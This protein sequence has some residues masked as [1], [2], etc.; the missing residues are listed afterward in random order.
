MKLQIKEA[1]L[2]DKVFTNKESSFIIGLSINNSYFK[3][4]NIKKLLVWSS[5]HAK[6]TYVMIPD[7]PMV[8]TFIALGY[9]KNKAEKIARLKANALENK[10]LRLVQ[11]LDLVYVT[12]IRWGSIVNNEHYIN[13][14][15]Q[16]KE[17]YKLDNNFN[18]AIR[19]ATVEVVKNNSILEITEEKINIGVEFFL[20]ELAFI[21]YSNLILEVKDTA[22]V[23]HRT[24]EVLRDI[25][26]KKY[27]F[28]SSP[29]VDFIVTD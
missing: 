5:L 16:I 29:N 22:Y 8:H 9:D 7:E 10:C 15:K 19:K 13:A 26:Y 27:S 12:I 1:S 14:L 21:S 18:Q 17:A 3:E 2:S 4:N 23:Y 11:E 28:H 6:S 20:K 25:I 24:T